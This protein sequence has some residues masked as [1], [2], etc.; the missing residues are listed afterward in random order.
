M[1]NT[2]LCSILV[3]YS[4]FIL[5]NKG[6]IVLFPLLA[7]SYMF[8]KSPTL[9]VK[10]SNHINLKLTHRAVATR[11]P[12]GGGWVGPHDTHI[13]QAL[14]LILSPS[15]KHSSLKRFKINEESI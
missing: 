3:S 14:K 2:I 1:L 9:L 15:T 11:T 8:N 4:I 6:W 7:S 10:I 5:F 13:H 12:G